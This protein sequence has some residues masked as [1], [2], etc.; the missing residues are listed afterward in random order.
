M[1]ASKITST[2][3]NQTSFIPEKPSHIHFDEDGR[4]HQSISVDNMYLLT[5]G[6]RHILQS[7]PQMCQWR[8]DCPRHNVSCRII[9]LSTCYAPQPCPHLVTTHYTA[10]HTQ[11][12]PCKI[13]VAIH[14]LQTTAAAPSYRLIVTSNHRPTIAYNPPA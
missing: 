10:V 8:V 6:S 11:K 2:S 14:F 4:I 3:Q 13:I 9:H 12:T 7:T 5:S 1:R